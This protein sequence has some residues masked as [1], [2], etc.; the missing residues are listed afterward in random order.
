MSETF[1]ASECQSVVR[2]SVTVIGHWQTFLQSAAVADGSVTGVGDRGSKT[3]IKL[4]LIAGLQG[5]V[6]AAAAAM[7]SLQSV[8]GVGS[9]LVTT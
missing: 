6:A 2:P 9:M 7:Q 4:P 5:L 3:S 1:L 8:F